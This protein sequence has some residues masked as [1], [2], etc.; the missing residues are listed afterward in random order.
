MVKPGHRRFVAT[1]QLDAHDIETLELASECISDTTDTGRVDQVVASPFSLSSRE[2]IVLAVPMNRRIPK[3]RLR[4]RQLS[5][6]AGQRLVVSLDNW[7][8]GSLY[9]EGHFVRSLGPAGNLSTEAAAL[10][11]RHRLEDQKSPLA[12]AIGLGI[13]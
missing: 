13:R 11:L 8:V 5:S 6:L 3:I 2:R 12:P 10:F 7:R 1:L 9:P 4:T